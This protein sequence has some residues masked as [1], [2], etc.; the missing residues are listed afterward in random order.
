MLVAGGVD[1]VVASVKINAYYGSVELSKSDV[2]TG[3]IAQ[4]QPLPHVH[5]QF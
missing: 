4:G 2:E 3:K 5:K 1:P